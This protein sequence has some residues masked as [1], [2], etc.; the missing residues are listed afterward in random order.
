MSISVKYAFPAEPLNAFLC[1]IH[2]VPREA[3]GLLRLPMLNETVVPI[4]ISFAAATSAQTFN[5]L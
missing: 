5:S 1:S 4:I 2:D 3:R